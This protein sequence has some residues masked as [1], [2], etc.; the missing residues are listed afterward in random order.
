MKFKLFFRLQDKPNSSE[1]ILNNDVYLVLLET[2]KEKLKG[3]LL[4]DLIDLH[5]IQATKTAIQYTASLLHKASLKAEEEKKK[6]EE[7]RKNKV[8]SFNIIFIQYNRGI[9]K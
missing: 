2:V 1:D 8:Y 9:R 4:A 7:M 3:Q 5:V 6:I